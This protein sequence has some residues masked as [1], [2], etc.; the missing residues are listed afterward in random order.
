MMRQRDQGD[1]LR[2]AQERLR[3]F[4]KGDTAERL[5]RHPISHPAR[6]TGFCACDRS[7]AGMLRI[8]LR[9]ALLQ[10]VLVLPF[11]QPKLRALR[12]LGARIGQHVHIA[13]GA[14]VDPT[15]PQLLTIEDDV[16][17]GMGARI[18]MHE[19]RRD[20]FR[21]GKCII[22]R[23]AFIGAYALIGPGI[24]IGENATVA[25][26]TPLDRDVP[27]GCTALGNPPRIVRRAETP[28]GK[29]APEE[30]AAEAAHA[31]GET[32]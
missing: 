7:L 9:G 23:G 8:W 17:I 32:C 24:E 19:F 14:W 2:E 21:A 22:R 30:V 6:P 20:E 10:T 25:A 31:D 15:Y 11:N 1:D 29:R 26:C 28:A 4:L 3:R 13:V 16:F 12:M 5:F 27:A 18:F